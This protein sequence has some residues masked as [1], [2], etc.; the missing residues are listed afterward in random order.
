MYKFI[1]WIVIFLLAGSVVGIISRKDNHV[2][3]QEEIKKEETYP[4]PN[5]MKYPPIKKHKSENGVVLDD[6][7][8]HIDDGGYYND[9]D[10]IT[11]GHETTHGINSV[12]RNKYY[13]GKPTNAFY[14]LEDR[15]IILNEPKT[16][17][18]VVARAVPKSLR[19]SVYKLYLVDQAASGW[20][21]RAL[22]ICDEWVSYTNGSA[23]RKDLQIKKR[24]ETVRYM[25]EFDV[26]VM[27]LAKVL[28]EEES[29][30]DSYDFKNFIRWNI[31][32]SMKIYNEEDEAKIYLE[33]LRTESD[34]DGLRS[35]ARNYFG[36]EWCKKVFGF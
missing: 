28:Q 10:L 13:Q 23:V 18:E 32:R 25:L 16:R 9:S 6:I 17:I 29:S 2:E 22:Y 1:L 7:R 31:E 33:K 36:L 26:Y 19:G 27:T 11:A 21:D 34:A 20:G 35:F 5:W 12:I 8:S 4:E 14:C 15:A 30:Y 24:A 3:H